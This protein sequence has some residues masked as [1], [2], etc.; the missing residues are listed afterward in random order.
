MEHES[1]RAAYGINF[2]FNN[3]GI[4]LANS[5]CNIQWNYEQ[6]TE[7]V[8]RDALRLLDSCTWGR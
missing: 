2:N 1:K 6:N 3:T 8:R 7:G 4:S 5:S